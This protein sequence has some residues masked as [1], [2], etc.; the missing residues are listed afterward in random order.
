MYAT[1]RTL[2]P[3]VARA[4]QISLIK[5]LAPGNAAAAAHAHRAQAGGQGG[6]GVPGSGSPAAADRERSAT[7]RRRAALRRCSN[8]AA[9]RPAADVPQRPAHPAVRAGQARGGGCRSCSGGRLCAGGRAAGLNC[10]RL[11]A[12]VSLADL[13]TRFCRFKLTESLLP[14]STPHRRPS[15]RWRS[16]SACASSRSGGGGALGSRTHGGKLAC[17]F[18]V[19]P[20]YLTKT[21]MPHPVWFAGMQP[22]PAGAEA[23]AAA[24]LH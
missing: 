22:A 3:F 21:A 8:A 23:C 4:T 10:V 6:G 18:A 20:L 12:A 2:R 14:A 19:H 11:R 17:T 16:A 5:P 24:A 13:P 7:L 15:A 9:A 1:A